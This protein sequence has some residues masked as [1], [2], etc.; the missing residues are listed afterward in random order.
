MAFSFFITAEHAMGK[1]IDAILNFGSKAL[2]V[3]IADAPAA[4]TVASVILPE[5]AA[6]IAAVGTAGTTMLAKAL[7]AVQ[8]ANALQQAAA[9][10][11]L[12]ISA[13]VDEVNALKALVPAAV[14]VAGSLGLGKAVTALPAAA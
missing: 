14:T 11:T 10:G 9:T 2:P 13:S 7:V 12:T 1:A 5:D 3:L 4:E 6:V 8:G